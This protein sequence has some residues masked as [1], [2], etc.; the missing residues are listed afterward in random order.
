MTDDRACDAFFEKLEMFETRKRDTLLVSSILDGKMSDRK[1]R[2]S[3][4]GPEE[5]GESGGAEEPPSCEVGAW[6]QWSECDKPCGGGVRRRTRDVRVSG[7][8]AIGQ[9]LSRSIASLCPARHEEETCNTHD[10]LSVS[11]FFGLP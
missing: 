5:A 9:G 3:S 6:G 4:V 11:D 1:A 2:P 8:G 7:G 10:C